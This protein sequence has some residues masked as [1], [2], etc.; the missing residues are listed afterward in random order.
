MT[1]LF[2]TILKAA[3]KKDLYERLSN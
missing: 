2:H 3:I 1:K